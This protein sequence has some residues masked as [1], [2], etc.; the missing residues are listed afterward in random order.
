MC[1]VRIIS[2]AYGHKVGNRLITKTKQ[3]EPFELDKTEAQRLVSL[4]VAEIVAED[5]ATPEIEPNTIDT[6]E[7]APEEETRPEG[8]YD[9]VIDKEPYSVDMSVADLRAAAKEK[10]ISFKVGTTKEEMVKA[11]NGYSVD[12]EELILTAADPV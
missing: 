6:S 4:G 7:N 3:S 8:V 1:R 2:G 12:S 5:V 10:G 11:L 9:A